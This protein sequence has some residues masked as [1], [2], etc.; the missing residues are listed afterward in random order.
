MTIGTKSRYSILHI[1]LL[2][3]IFLFYYLVTELFIRLYPDINKHLGIIFTIL[4]K[5]FLDS[6]FFLYILIIMKKNN[7]NIKSE[8]KISI[9]KKDLLW[10][11]LSGFGALLPVAVLSYYLLKDDSYIVAPRM[12][13]ILM[14][15][16]HYLTLVFSFL[17][18]C[19][20]GPFIEELVFRGY[21]WKIFE[22]KKLNKIIVL[23]ITSFLFASIHLEI[24]RFLI[25]FT[26]GIIIGFLRMRTDRMG[27]SV[28]AH[29]TLNIIGFISIVLSANL[30]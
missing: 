7:V 26:L 14:G 9:M 23:L 11:I 22:E 10:G 3:I 8:L 21:L 30:E 1:V 18:I 19:I 25:L 5:I 15:G 4:F 2:F 29:M 16:S 13:N 28:V 12:I 17:S 27:A 20:L 24:N 6:S